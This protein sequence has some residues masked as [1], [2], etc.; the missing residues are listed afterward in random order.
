MQADNAAIGVAPV[1]GMDVVAKPAL[2]AH[3]LEQPRRHAAPRDARE[4]APG[5]RGFVAVRKA[6]EGVDHMALLEALV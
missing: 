2:F 4:Y 5:E 3:L 6:L 1:E